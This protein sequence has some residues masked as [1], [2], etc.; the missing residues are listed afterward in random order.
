MLMGV[1]QPLE[2]NINASG[3]ERA[4]PVVSS[5]R[6]SISSAQVEGVALDG[7]AHQWYQEGNR[8]GQRNKPRTHATLSVHKNHTLPPT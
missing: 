2:G 3:E 4:A 6:Q 7:T 5:G 1:I 8:S